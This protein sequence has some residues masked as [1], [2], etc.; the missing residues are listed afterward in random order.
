M[1]L[2]IKE[3]ELA[4]VAADNTYAGNKD[5]TKL[6]QTLLNEC[7]IAIECFKNNDMIVNHDKFQSM[8]ISSKKE[9]LSCQLFLKNGAENTPDH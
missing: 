3:A 2:F 7:A 4:N 8:V 6:L 9:N 1:I 5:L